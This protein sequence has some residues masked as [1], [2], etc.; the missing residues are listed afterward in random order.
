MP[1]NVLIKKTCNM[2][3]KHRETIIYHLIIRNQYAKER[4]HF[5]IYVVSGNDETYR[6]HMKSE[7]ISI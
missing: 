3:S 5:E 2:V 4:T 1:P 6:F 7:S